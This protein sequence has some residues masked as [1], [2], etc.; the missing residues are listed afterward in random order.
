MYI[1]QSK[2]MVK[3]TVIAYIILKYFGHSP[4]NSNAILNL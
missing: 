3:V 4:K 2:L 1:H